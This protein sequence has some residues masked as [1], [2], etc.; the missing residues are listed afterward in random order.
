ME[1]ILVQVKAI[2]SNFC[3]Y[4][5]YGPSCISVKSIDA[6]LYTKLEVQSLLHNI[7]ASRSVEGQVK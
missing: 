4:K 2:H 1:K 6:L 5:Y 7:C 3:K